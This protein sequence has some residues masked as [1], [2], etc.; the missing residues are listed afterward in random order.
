T[1]ILSVHNSRLNSKSRCAAQNRARS[2]LRVM[3]VFVV[4]VVLADVDHRQFPKLSEVHDFVERPLA[5]GAYSEET[6]RDTPISQTL[7]CER[8][9]GG[10]S[11]AA[12]DDGIGPEITRGGVSDMHRS[13]FATA[14]SGFFPQQFGEHAIRGR[15]FG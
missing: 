2:G 14:I 6:D 11:D 12:S 8:R 4:E 3:G 5:K 9:S 10:N 1:N 7:R 13:A 15:A